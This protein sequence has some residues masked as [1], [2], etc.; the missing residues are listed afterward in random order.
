M[1]TSL[2]LARMVEVLHLKNFLKGM[3]TGRGG[4][5]HRPGAPLKNFLKG[6]ETGGRFGEEGTLPL[7]QKLP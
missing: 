7:P 3:E 5:E 6:M 1:E 4:S 2:P